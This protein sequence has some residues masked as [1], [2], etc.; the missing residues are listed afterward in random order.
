MLGTI[1]GHENRK[2]KKKA[3]SSVPREKGTRYS[4]RERG[5]VQSRHE[6]K[7]LGEGVQRGKGEGPL[8][9]C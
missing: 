6:I 1:N 2:K 4:E 7:H 9:G 5:R 3:E 8:I